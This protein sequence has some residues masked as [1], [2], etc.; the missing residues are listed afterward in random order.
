MR[1]VLKMERLC[2][3]IIVH[4]KDSGMQRHVYTLTKHQQRIMN[5]SLFSTKQAYEQERRETC[6]MLSM[7]CTTISAFTRGYTKSSGLLD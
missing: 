5:F 7:F 3:I 2:T 1:S 6:G 4:F